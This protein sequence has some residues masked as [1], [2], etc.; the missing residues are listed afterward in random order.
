MNLAGKSEQVTLPSRQR[1]DKGKVWKGRLK[2][3]HGNLLATDKV[4]FV[5]LDLAIRNIS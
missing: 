1:K 5:Y 2:R 4:E 3:K